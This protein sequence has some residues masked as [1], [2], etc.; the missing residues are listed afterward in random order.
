MVR[1]VT[2]SLSDIP[3]EM[4]ADGHICVIPLTV[5]IEDV[6]YLDGVDFTHEEFFEMLKQAKSFPKTSHP[7]AEAFLSVFKS[8]VDAG[9]SVICICASPY[10]SGTIDAARTARDMLGY[11]KIDIID[12]C[13]LSMGEGLIVLTACEMA[14]KGCGHDEIVKR[15]LLH[16]ENGEG[17]VFLDTVEYLHKG[18]RLSTSKALIVEKLRIRP[19][20][21][22][23]PKGK[24]VMAGRALGVR[25]AIRWLTEAVGRIRTDFTQTTVAIGYTVKKEIAEE[26]ARRLCALYKMGNIIFYK[27]G[28]A[29]GAH[30]GPGCSAVFFEA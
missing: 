8:A 3:K 5:T 12:S 26:I 17:L 30:T 25:K 27:A 28:S 11:G 20:L 16:A 10:I 29:I 21:R 15:A 23:D 1:I 13:S 19:V 4:N 18:G 14:K 9:D 6:S 22:I 7:S 2:D 24:L